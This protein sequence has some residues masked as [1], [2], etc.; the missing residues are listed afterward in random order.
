MKIIPRTFFVLAICL[1]WFFLAAEL[2]AQAGATSGTSNAGATQNPSSM[3][4]TTTEDDPDI[5]PFAQGAV[6]A[7]AYFQKR[8]EHI[9]RLRG[10]D[11]DK[12][13]D[14]HLRGSAI[15]MMEQQ[16]IRHAAAVRAAATSSVPNSALVNNP[17]WIS[18]GPAPI[19]PGTGTSVQVSGRVTAIAVH[20]TAPQTIYVGAAQGGVYR[21]LDGGTTW[22]PIMDSAMSLAIGAIAIDPL[23][24]STIYV[25]TG[26][27]NF[28]PD[29]FFG[30]GVYRID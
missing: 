20:P 5:S 25:G 13:V 17:A 14:S 3:P 19:M 15:R 26:E 10:L 11:K 28:T 9:M 24:P 22:T 4:P 16:E 12:P 29:T 27:A 30:V 7:G 6:D 23:Q 2:N 21:S 1:G 18:I 8:A